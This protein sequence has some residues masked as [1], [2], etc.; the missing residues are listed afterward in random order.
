MAPGLVAAEA[1]R[2]SEVLGEE[3]VLLAAAQ[4]EH[5]LEPVRDID[6]DETPCRFVVGGRIGEQETKAQIHLYQLGLL[7][8]VLNRTLVLPNVD[9]SRLGSC[10]KRPFSFYYS[11]DALSRL[12]IKTVTQEQ[13]LSWTERKEKR[14]TA[15]VVSLLKSNGHSP[16]VEINTSINTFVP[17]P[18]VCA[19]KM[20]L[21][22][23]NHY[24]VDFNAPRNYATQRSDDQSAFI[25]AIVNSL[26]SNIGVRGTRLKGSP[27]VLIFDHDVLRYPFLLPDTHIAH[28]ASLTETPLPKYF[29]HYPYA[30]TWTTLADLMVS[31]NSP[32]IAVHWR[33]ETLPAE[34]LAP[35][36]TELVKTLRTLKKKHPT[37]RN[38]W[39]S[40][41]YPLDQLEKAALADADVLKEPLTAHSTTYTKLLTPEHHAAMAAFL[42]KFDSA[43]MGLRLTSFAAEEQ[44]IQLPPSVVALLPP[45]GGG[46]KA[47]DRR[48]RSLDSAPVGIVDKLVSAQA[49]I[50]LAGTAGYKSG[51]LVPG[52]CGKLSSF[53][54]QIIGAREEAWKEIRSHEGRGGTLWNTPRF[55][56]R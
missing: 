30:E 1:A 8:S 21:D 55:C 16:L 51:V 37:L 19:D 7:A 56:M 47:V 26:R 45:D 29:E 18:A 36:G 42:A 9:S 33:T 13:F 22:F 3:E 32:M 14:A 40:T 17:P 24:P 49:A 39:M 50:F 43:D 52:A 28:M 2:S 6:C 44:L 25:E 34:I 15:Q 12:G 10:R 4:D 46:L 38:V 23:T 5:P 54:D 31:S 35:C 48:L 53:T 20:R 11:E 41:D 27:E